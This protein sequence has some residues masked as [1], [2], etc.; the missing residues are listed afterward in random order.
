MTGGDEH[1]SALWL[2]TLQRLA[3]R[4]AHDVRN[5]L[6]GVAVNVEVVRS[7]A[8]RGAEGSAIAPFATAAAAQVEVLSA[9]VDALMTLLR[10]AGAAVD[11]GALLG[12][13]AALVQDTSGK[14]VIDLDLPVGSGSVT[15]GAPGDA[16]RLAVAASLLAALE[17]PGGAACRLGTDGTPTVYISSGAGGALVVAQDIV[18]TVMAAGIQLRS[19]PD[20]ITLTFPPDPRD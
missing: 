14:Q 10:P 11:V 7:R 1:L 3:N 9:Q 15:S 18:D 8:G 6:N 5:A 13:L 20:G 4:A 16:T 19:S 2:T 12:R 17:Q